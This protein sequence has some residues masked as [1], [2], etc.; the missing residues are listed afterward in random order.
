[1]LSNMKKIIFIIFI[2]GAMLTGKAQVKEDLKRANMY[3]ERAFY[4]EAIP[5]YESVTKK[6]RNPTIVQNLGDC[7]YNINNM[8]KASRVYKYLVENY[9]DKISD[10]YYFKYANTLK[11]INNYND[12]YKVMREFYTKTNNEIELKKLESS[13]KYLENIKALGNRF[14][15]KNLEINTEN[16]EFGAIHHNERLVFAASKKGKN[17]LDKVYR[18][19]SQHYLDL[20]EAP[21]SQINLGLGDSIVKSLPGD[22]NT[23]LHEAN[24]IFTKDGNTAYF[25]RNNL[26]KGKRQKDDKEITHLQLYKADYIQGEWKN[27]TSLHFN[28]DSYSNEHPALSPDEKTLYFASDMPG[29]YGSFDIYSVNINIDGSYG[30]PKNLGE[31]INTD[32]KEQFPFISKDNKLYFSSNGHIGFGS[33]DVFVSETIEGKF[34][35]PDNV[36]LPINSGYDDFSFNINT[37]TKEGYFASNRPEGRGNDDIYKIIESKPLIIE[38]CKQ[39]I[40]GVI[41]DESTKEVLA[42][43]TI[44]LKDNNN[45]EVESTYTNTDG[46]FQLN[47]KCETSY[48]VIA[49]K[50]EYTSNQKVLVLQSERNKD[51]DASMTLKSLELIKREEALAL[52]QQKVKEQTQKI[53]AIAKLKQKKK[54]LAD[55]AITNEKEIKRDKERIIINP[56]DIFFDYN[57]WYIRRDVKITLDKVI[58]L[59]RKYP[60]MKVEVGTHTDTRG[61]AKYNL[62]LSEKRANS[63]KE[64]IVK[65]NIEA[66]RVFAKGYGETKPIIHCKTDESCSEE[67]HEINRR[68]EFVVTGF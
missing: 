31:T 36:G 5:I 24:A 42:N 60:E 63:V 66:D 34:S 38:E 55:D 68:C 13:I 48:I 53:E 46:K 58:V 40:S 35:K 51:N 14:K 45:I 33:L 15:I 37:D 64:Y 59:M 17:F 3:F 43:T 7:Y 12:A 52:A 21:L 2:L 22:I 32:K 1:M 47:A 20:Y 41:T 50:E 23:K 9:S 6:M 10:E 67:E 65:N 16:S 61:N 54:K 19:D 18:W 26:V 39:F 30:T 56:G 57:L 25:T 29:G 62:E 28:N 49:T 8:G 44:T 11:A 27:V 4:S